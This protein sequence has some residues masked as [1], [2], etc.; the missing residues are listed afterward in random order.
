YFLNTENNEFIKIAKDD[1]NYLIFKKNIDEASFYIKSVNGKNTEEI[2]G[3]ENISIYKNS[4]ENIFGLEFNE[5][6]YE[7]L[8]DLVPDFKK[9]FVFKKVLLANKT[10]VFKGMWIDSLDIKPKDMKSEFTIE[11]FNLHSLITKDNDLPLIPNLEEIPKVDSLPDGTSEKSEIP[12]LEITDADSVVPLKE[13]SFPIDESILVVN[14]P[15]HT[16]NQQSGVIIKRLSRNDSQN[17]FT[18][19]ISFLV[20]NQTKH[21]F[22]NE[23]INMGKKDYLYYYKIPTI[24]Q[25]RYFYSCL[26]TYDGRPKDPLPKN[27]KELYLIYNSKI[28]KFHWSTNKT[29]WVPTKGVPRIYPLFIKGDI[30]SSSGVA[31]N[32]SKH[33]PL[34]HKLI[35]YKYSSDSLLLTFNTKSDDKTLFFLKKD[36][37]IWQDQEPKD[38]TL[39]LKYLDNQNEWREFRS[40]S[41]YYY[42]LYDHEYIKILYF[43]QHEMQTAKIPIS[44][45][46]LGEISQS[47]PYLIIKGINAYWSDKMEIP[48]DTKEFSLSIH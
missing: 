30:L 48:S 46:I 27:L 16:P 17:D 19:T 28:D 31:L 40:G 41:T 11:L 39:V 9:Y 34:F 44:T 33:Y 20:N 4:D 22:T 6:L 47:T 21:V 10:K 12:N 24:S 1:Q 26:L 5:T 36:S 43:N 18:A 35:Q 25:E 29:A 8:A 2:S 38:S 32:Q 15:F 13:I 23:R 7:K 45:S 3:F 42:E 14:S 37:H